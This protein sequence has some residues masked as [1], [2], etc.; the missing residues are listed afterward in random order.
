VL[1]PLV[2]FPTSAPK[3]LSGRLRESVCAPTTPLLGDAPPSVSNGLSISEREQR[4]RVQLLVDGLVGMSDT[5]EHRSYASLL[6]IAPM[7]RS[8]ASL[9]CIAPM[10]RSYAS[11]QCIAPMHRSYASLL[12]IAPMHRSYASL[13]CIA[14]MHRSYTHSPPSPPSS[15]PTSLS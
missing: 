12:C 8:Y 2:H 11:L 14:P 6:C 9:L 13:L 7:H 10:H 15:S 4:R 3:T 1:I 5:P